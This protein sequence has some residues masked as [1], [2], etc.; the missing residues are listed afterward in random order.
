M[1]YFKRLLPISMWR[2][3]LHPTQTKKD[4]AKSQVKEAGAFLKETFLR[5]SV[6]GQALGR[7]PEPAPH[8]VI[9]V[10]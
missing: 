5:T 4:G 3:I 8:T 2:D 10:H 7:Y 1:E 9:L 6:K